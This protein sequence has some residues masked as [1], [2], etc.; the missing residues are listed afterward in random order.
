MGTLLHPESEF[1]LPEPLP[2]VGP[3][4]VRVIGDADPAVVLIH[5]LGRVAA[6]WQEVARHVQGRI[7]LVLPDNPGFGRS[8]HLEVPPS[9]EDHARLHHETLLDLDLAPPY[10]VAGLSLGGMIAPT[11]AARLESDCASLVM[12][13]ASSRESGFLR[14]DPVSLVR[15]AGRVLGTASL[16]HVV[17]MPE[18]VSAEL[19]ERHPGLPEALDDLQDEEGF[20]I[21]NGSRQILAAMSWQIGPHLDRLPEKRLVVVGSEDRLV[22]VENSRRL[23]EFTA[24]P[25]RV[26]PGRGHDLSLDAP[27]QVAQILCE[28]AG[29]RRIGKHSYGK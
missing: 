26:L 3:L 15:M 8:S 29:V 19:L 20:R 10:H 22:P 7:R 28:M 16:S 4:G 18:L 25:C 11:L 21:V 17:N 27:E 5:G 14:L 2:G 9:I 23:A 6:V 1:A 13:C 24:S 12:F